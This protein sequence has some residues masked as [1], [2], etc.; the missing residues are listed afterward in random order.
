MTSTARVF[1]VCSLFVLGAACA[2][3]GSGIRPS[4]DVVPLAGAGGHADG[5]QGGTGSGE[6]GGGQ[7]PAGT[8]GVGPQG[9][10]SSGGSA[11]KECPAGRGPEM[12]R[13]ALPDREPFCIDSTEVTQ[14]QYAQ[15]LAAKV[16][17]TAQSRLHCQQINK[18]F[19]PV[20]EG[21][22]VSGCP[23]GLFDPEKRG[24]LPMPCA[25]FCDAVA[26]CEWSGKR[27][28][29]AVGG[30][31]A[32]ATESESQKSEKSQW[33]LACSQGGKTQYPYGDKFEPGKCD[34]E[35]KSALTR[36]ASESSCTGTFPPFDR[37]KDLSGSLAEWEDAEV[38]EGNPLLRGG[39]GWGTEL[40][41]CDR[42][43]I[44]FGG[45]SGPDIG[46]R[47]CADQASE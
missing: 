22:H 20:I 7:S 2:S 36:P 8:S 5:G 34:T 17:P 26:F 24:D 19:E 44:A 23:A 38:T 28:C 14:G 31:P 6:G 4:G 21:D 11:G 10:A 39:Y 35:G 37:I 12:V 30:G 27:L 25:Q 3:E 16:D 41:E 42:P 32:P 45:S 33:Y 47:C 18:G 1:V 29:G 43:G 46:F 40:F 13:I 15:F 9:G